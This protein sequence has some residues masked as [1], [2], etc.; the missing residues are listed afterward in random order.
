MAFGLT[1]QP[2][3]F[4]RLMQSVMS[5]PHSVWCMIYL[6]DITVFSSTVDEHLQ[7]LRGNLAK[8]G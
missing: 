6:D 1:K 3:T 7:R 5:D 8:V 2:A 4:Q